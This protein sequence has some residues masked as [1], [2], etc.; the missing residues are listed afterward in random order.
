MP[1]PDEIPPSIVLNRRFPTSGPRNRFGAILFIEKEGFKPLLDAA[2]IAERFDIAIMSTKGM[3][4]TASR[5]ADRN[6]VRR[7]RH[8]AAGPARLR[9]LRLHHRRHAAGI[10]PALSVQPRLP[11]HRSRPAPRRCRWAGERRT[12]SSASARI[13]SAKAA[14][15]RR[16][17]ATE[18]EIDFLLE[19]QQRVEL[20]AMTSPE[21][22]AFL[23]R[24]L[25]RMASARSC[26]TRQR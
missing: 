10:D 9:R 19:R 3:S 4:V 14:T 22:V 24:K 18:E 23:E 6:A 12:C 5:H 26:R 20:N 8:P 16:Y 11:R 15:L 21:F 2:R 13:S 7:P 1:T 25:P 17:G